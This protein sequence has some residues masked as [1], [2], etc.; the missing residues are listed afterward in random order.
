MSQNTALIQALKRSLKSHGLT[1]ADVAKQLGMSE[2]NIKRMFSEQ[3]FYLGVFDQICQLMALEISDLAKEVE[4]AQHSLEQL[5]EVQEQK[6]AA[7]PKLLL[8]TFLVVNGIAF[9]EI[10]SHY[11]FN[12]PE[13]IG[14]LTQLDRLK[15]IELLPNNR[16]KLLISP[17]F[18]W[19]R[20]GPIQR[21][22][23]QALQND[24]LNAPF[25][26][27]GETLHFVSG[28]ISSASC[29]ALAAKLKQ[30]VTDFTVHNH[31]DTKLPF[32]Q[33]YVTSMI[34]GIRS[35]KPKTFESFCYEC[36]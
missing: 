6:L 28:I 16:V 1:Y 36:S 19:R 29:D 33:R 9:D 13:A 34:L 21:F 17:N 4:R 24:F 15:L 31:A 2:A 23:T 7:D 3:R 27:S 10:V 26:Q 5:T 22:F 18:T 25:D 30:I 11:R 35:W 12:E 8:M 14:Y 20:N 32:E